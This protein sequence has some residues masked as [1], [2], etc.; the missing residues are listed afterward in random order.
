MF[1]LT[2]VAYNPC[3]TKYG[4]DS[5]ETWPQKYKG[6]HNLIKNLHQRFMNWADFCAER[7]GN[8]INFAKS[9]YITRGHNFSE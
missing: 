2:F 4:S 7:L 5:L 6:H 9:I 1:L 8:T 3:T